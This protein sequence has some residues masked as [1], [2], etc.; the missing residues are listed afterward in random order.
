M[1]RFSSSADFFDHSGCADIGYPELGS[2][3]KIAP[4]IESLTWVLPAVTKQVLAFQ[5]TL[6]E[7]P[8]I[9]TGTP[10]PYIP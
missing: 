6:V 8:P 1:Q 4:G 9:P 3:E 10:E 5:K 2:A 7:E